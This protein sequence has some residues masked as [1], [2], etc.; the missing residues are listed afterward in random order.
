MLPLQFWYA[1]GVYYSFASA[2]FLG[3][4]MSRMLRVT[5]DYN[6]VQVSELSVEYGT[7]STM[8]PSVYGT[9]LR[10]QGTQTSSIDV[11]CSTVKG[12]FLTVL[13]VKASTTLQLQNQHAYK[14]TRTWALQFARI[15]LSSEA[16][17]SIQ[18]LCQ[19]ASVHLP[20]SWLFRPCHKDTL[21][22][23]IMG[24]QLAHWSKLPYPSGYIAILVT[25]RFTAWAADTRSSICG[26][27]PA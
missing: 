21:E 1:A 24:C 16:L 20:K 10:V 27:I 4:P 25:V 8:L 6:K 18:E 12:N 11:L 3:M 7:A 5:I 22:V 26:G 14:C 9:F 2:L 17:P 13:D 15:I 19:S 23:R